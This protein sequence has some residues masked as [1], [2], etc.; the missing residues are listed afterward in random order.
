MIIFKETLTNA[1]QQNCFYCIDHACPEKGNFLQKEHAIMFAKT[2]A[3]LGYDAVELCGGEPLLHPD[4]CGLI[5]EIK[6]IEGIQTVILT[7][8]GLLL[9]EKLPQLQ[10]AGLDAVNLHL[11]SMSAEGYTAS[12]GLSQQLNV[13]LDGMWQTVARNIPL[14][15]T[16]VLQEHSVSQW[17]VA[18]GLTR[19]Y[20]I[21]VRF[22]SFGAVSSD[23]PPER[24]LE[25][26]RPS[27]G[28]NLTFDGTRYRVDGW[29]GSFCFGHGIC[30]AEDALI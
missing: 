24:V 19:R 28:D 22:A 14:T 18:V 20:P 23:C 8:N 2:A 4:I 13:V 7:T 15:M 3:A 30:L 9:R 16:V 27:I 21:T 12:T 25:A 10:T 6:A 17:G 26:L 5:A 1:C 29:K 11:D